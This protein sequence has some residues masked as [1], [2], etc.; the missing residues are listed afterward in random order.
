M[1]L[2]GQVIGRA[3]CRQPGTEPPLQRSIDS[4]YHRQ[5]LTGNVNSSFR[6]TILL[7]KWTLSWRRDLLTSQRS[8]N[9]S[10]VVA[11]EGPWDA[12]APLVLT[13]PGLCILLAAFTID[14]A[15]TDAVR[16]RLLLGRNQPLTTVSHDHVR[17]QRQISSQ[18]S[19]PKAASQHRDGNNRHISSQ[20]P[21]PTPTTYQTPLAVAMDGQPVISAPSAM[22]MRSARLDGARAYERRPGNVV[23]DHDS[24]G[25][26]RESDGQ[27]QRH[28]HRPREPSANRHRGP[29]RDHLR[30]T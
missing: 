12:Q 21:R 25:A 7:R 2:H 1:A 15:D 8:N 6:R 5:S 19:R 27:R 20:A 29:R 30:L 4:A 28:G 13:P 3:T 26:R 10:F 18:S 22:T 17:R 9:G 11:S 16:R 24:H 23:L 14:G